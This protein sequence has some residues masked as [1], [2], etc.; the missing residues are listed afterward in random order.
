[1]LH[2]HV[3]LVVRF[4]Q[5]HWKYAEL[6]ADR[7]AFVRR[8]AD[9][10]LIEQPDLRPDVVVSI[11]ERIVNK[12]CD[13]LHQRVKMKTIDHIQ[14]KRRPMN[15]NNQR[16]NIRRRR[17]RLR[18]DS[19]PARAPR[20]VGT[21]RCAADAC[22]CSTARSRPR[23]RTTVQRRR[24]RR[25][26]RTADTRRA[27][28]RSDCLRGRCVNEQTNDAEPDGRCTCIASCLSGAW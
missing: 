24:R 5:R 1:M 4:V 14:C 15:N 19:S 26:R 13:Q 18:R 6:T 27:P 9:C 12:V 16:H 10:A 7:R 23:R 20:P 3:R 21:T 8:I 11:E 2:A 25:R 17:A 22:R 28:R